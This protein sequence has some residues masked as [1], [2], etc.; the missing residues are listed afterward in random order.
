MNEQATDRPIPVESIELLR[1]DGPTP[2]AP[3]RFSSFADA[4]AWLERM[5]QTFPKTG[6]HGIRFAVR[7]RN[8]D[9]CTGRYNAR[10]PDNVTFV[11][12]DISRQVKRQASFLTNVVSY[13]SAGQHQFEMAERILE[14]KLE[15]PCITGPTDSEPT[16]SAG[17]RL[18][19][20]TGHVA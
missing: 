4:N 7:W 20:D 11:G 16:A 13:H 19:D 9:T 14:G 6:Y 1:I 17:S 10:H 2:S 8:G 12:Y 18:H 15:L 3:Q 5:S